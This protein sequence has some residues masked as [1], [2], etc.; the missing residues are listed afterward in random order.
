MDVGRSLGQPNFAWYRK[1][2]NAISYDV[3]QKCIVV[4]DLD[5]FCVNSQCISY[6][7]FQ[8]TSLKRK[9][10]KFLKRILVNQM[11]KAWGKLYKLVDQIY[12]RNW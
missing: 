8:I 10:E 7:I 6:N 9:I 5:N 2:F 3:P 11:K 12:Y 1:N 4:S